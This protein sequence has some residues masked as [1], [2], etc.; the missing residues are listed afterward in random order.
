[1]V[2]P[3]T[4]ITE[5]IKKFLSTKGKTKKEPIS[6]DPLFNN[7]ISTL[8]KHNLNSKKNIQ[9]LRNA[10]REFVTA[11]T[12]LLSNDLLF[13]KD[14]KHNQGIFDQ[15]TSKSRQQLSGIHNLYKHLSTQLNPREQKKFIHALIESKDP[16]QV[17]RDVEDQIR[18]NKSLGLNIPN[19][20][21]NPGVVSSSRV[22]ASRVA[23]LR[24]FQER[25]EQKQQKRFDKEL[26]NQP[27]SKKRPR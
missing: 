4:K 22:S 8:K 18:L 6:S 19:Q 15:L 26:N 17:A 24:F 23:A 2:T 25:R 13:N 5:I 3:T 16:A 12:S 20:N 1:M 9:T 27:T 10:R 14:K 11:L 21:Y 7:L